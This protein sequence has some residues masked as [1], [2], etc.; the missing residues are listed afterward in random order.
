M[1]IEIWAKNIL[2]TEFGYSV[3]KISE[4]DSKSPD[5]YVEGF[6]ENF[7][8]ELKTKEDDEERIEVFQKALKEGKVAEYIDTTGRKNTISKI[9]RDASEQLNSI[10]TEVHFKLI[11]LMAVGKNQEMKKDQFKG[12]LYGNCSIFDLD[13]T[14]TIPCYYFNFNDFYHVKNVI[15]GA[16][17]STEESAQLCL[18]TLSPNYQ[19]IRESN[20]AKKFNGA[21]I[22]PVLEEKAQKAMILDSDIDRRDTGACIKYLKKK[23]KKDKIQNMQMGYYS[24]NILVP[25]E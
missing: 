12:S 8:I 19:K 14:Y 15:D 6:D 13:A 5:F 18:N 11:W 4:N 17:I 20:L 22:D 25:N 16:L 10:T 1:N 21:C 7:L 23:Y 3:T 9:I 24:A 2:E